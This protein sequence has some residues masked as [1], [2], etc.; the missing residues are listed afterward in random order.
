MSRRLPPL[1]GLV[2]FD[3]AARHLSFRK[4]ADAL[5]ITPSAVSHRIAGL[6]QAL[7]VPLFR[8]QPRQLSL[9][10]AGARLVGPLASALDQVGDAAAAISAQARNSLTVT[11]APTFAMHWLLPRLGQFRQRH[12]DIDVRV[13]IDT[14]LIDFRHEDVDAG[15]RFGRGGWP[16]LSARLVL[17]E[18]LTAV[19]SPRLLYGDPPLRLPDDLRHHTLLHYGQR[20]DDW[21]FWLTAVGVGGIDPDAGPRFETLSLATQAASEGL[22]IAIADPGLVADDLRRGR[23]VQP[24]DQKIAADSGHYL[25]HPPAAEEDP[26]IR[27]FADWL[28]EAVADGA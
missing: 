24:F 6:E 17:R 9:T 22:G 27:A 23:L 7:G 21:R 2:A 15:I 26:R 10:E 3:E 14:R 11:T 16:G 13:S 28:F 1:A 5:N 12:P 20:P 18:D 25:V 8:R 19:C 4:A